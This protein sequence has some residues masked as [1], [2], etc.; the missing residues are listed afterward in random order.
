M[1]LAFCARCRWSDVCHPRLS[2]L[3]FDADGVFVTIPKSKTDQLS[4]GEVVFVQFADHPAC[5][6]LLSQDNIAK[7]QYGECDGFFQPRI[8]TQKG[9]QSGFWNTTVSYST[10]LIDLKIFHA[11]LGLDSAHF[12]EHSGRCRGATAA[13]DAGVAWPDLMLH[14]RWKSMAT[15]LGYLANSRRRQRHVAHALERPPA[16]GNLQDL[17]FSPQDSPFFAQMI[18]AMQSLAIDTLPGSTSGVSLFWASFTDLTLCGKDIEIDKERMAS[19]KLTR[20]MCMKKRRQ[21]TRAWADLL[22]NCGNFMSSI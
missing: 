22:I 10:A 2:H 14:G 6:V 9:V 12:S 3:Q 15:L 19:P 11:S 7:L 4:K 16:S 13:S 20:E 8:T 17:P 1:C 18:D 5:L 21:N